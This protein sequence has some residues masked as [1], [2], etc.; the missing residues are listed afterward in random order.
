MPWCGEYPRLIGMVSLHRI[1]KIVDGE[2]QGDGSFEVNS[3]MSLEQ[4]GSDSL[5]FF[6]DKKDHNASDTRA[7]A[8]LVSPRSAGLFST[9]RI[10]VEDPYLAY[11]KA[12]GLF[13]HDVPG[14]VISAY[15][16]VAETAILGSGVSIGE[17]ST[18]GDRSKISDSV[19]IGSGVRIGGDVSIGSGSVIEDN[20]VIMSHSQI[21]MRCFISAGAVIGSSGFGYAPV[22]GG[23]QKIEQLG[24]VVIG[25]DVDI[26]ANTTIDRGALDDTVIENGVKLD[27]LIQVAHNVRIGEN[28]A[29]AGCSGIA[30]STII[31]RRCKIGGRAAILGHLTI[32]DDVTLLVNSMVTSSITAAGEYASMIPVQPAKQWRK[33]VAIIR[34][35]DRLS[36]KITGSDEDH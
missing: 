16:R 19:F 9:H 35:L 13:S 26:G 32:A 5:T 24:R 1:A 31:G 8:V 25:D 34:R 14:A 30:G 33:N 27:N 6:V 2:V 15:A 12:S 20:S 18:I 28:T 29:I 11:A 22:D 3:L 10:I 36:R 23:W 4:A 7:G 21:G 17:F